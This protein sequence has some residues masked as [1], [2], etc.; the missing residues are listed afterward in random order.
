MIISN[1]LFQLYPFS[2]SS[3][4][5]SISSLPSYISAKPTFYCCST[6]PS[7]I[8]L[9]NGRFTEKSVSERSEIR[10]GLPSK[11]RMASETLEL[12]KDCQLSVRQVNPR[13]Y[14]AEIPQLSNLQVW[15]QR[16]K[17][18]V[19]KLLSGDLDLGIV[20]LDTMSEFGQVSI[21]MD[22]IRLSF[23]LG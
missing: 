14:V 22:M 19:R 7:S 21:D 10:L 12:L 5:F 16:P 6:S 17:D 11:G 4:S 9:V 20:G 3:S 23:S 2:S 15:F 8:T 1:S 13:Q 18:I